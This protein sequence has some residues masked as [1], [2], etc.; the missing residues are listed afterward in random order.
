MLFSTSTNPAS[1]IGSIATSFFSDIAPFVYII[2][3]IAL[4]FLIIDIIMAIVS[5]DKNVSSNN[6]SK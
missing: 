5:K 4:A 6:N 1:G 2:L 3:G